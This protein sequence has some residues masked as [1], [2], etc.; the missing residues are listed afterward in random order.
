[1]STTAMVA[2]LIA[3]PCSLATYVVRQ[4]FFAE[5][6]YEALGRIIEADKLYRL[7]EG[8]SVLETALVILLFVAL[9]VLLFS[10]VK[11]ETGYQADNV[12][13]YSSHLSLHAALCRKAVV[14]TVLASLGSIA[15]TADVFLRRITERYKLGAADGAGEVLGG[16]ILPV[17]GWFWLIV[18]AISAG[19]FLYALHFANVMNQEVVHRYSLSE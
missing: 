7:Y 3:F 9:C 2:A 13:N 16:V 19:A 11:Q 17:Y 4:M 15:T 18:F 12:H 14:L 1:M 8:L 10:L 5:Y 6:S